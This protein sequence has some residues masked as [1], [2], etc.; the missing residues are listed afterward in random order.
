MNWRAI[1]L[2]AVTLP[3]VTAG[4]AQARKDPADRS[5]PAEVATDPRA[6]YDPMFAQGGARR[7]ARGDTWYEFALK[8][9]NPK[10]HDYGAWIEERRRAFLSATVANRYFWYSLC[11][12]AGLA[13]ALLLYAKQR[14]DYGRALG[15][16]AEC[17]AD[18]YN[19]DQYSRDVARDAVDKYNRHIEE[20]NRV[21]EAAETGTVTPAAAVNSDAN[22]EIERLHGELNA[23]LTENRKLKAE[24]EQKKNQLAEFS[25]RVD[26][27][28]KHLDGNTVPVPAGDDESSNSALIARVNQLQQELYAGKGKNQRLKGA[29]P[30]W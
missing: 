30:C 9:F 10:N 16:A 18:L 2:L 1:W 4:A 6:R 24:L 20:C 29:G 11:T 12:T 27:L 25:A 26:S 13:L 17:M 5:R 19:Q 7:I 21:I 14:L 3:A 22:K 28:S 8:Q 23:A 15:I